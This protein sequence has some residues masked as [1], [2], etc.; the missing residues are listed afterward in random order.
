MS[1]SEN[2]KRMMELKDKDIATLTAQVEKLEKVVKASEDLAGWAENPDGKYNCSGCVWE[3]NPETAVA[4]CPGHDG[5][6]DALELFKKALAALKDMKAPL[7]K[8]E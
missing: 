8:Q 6:P 7:D 3:G 5:L 4:D 1:L 2:I